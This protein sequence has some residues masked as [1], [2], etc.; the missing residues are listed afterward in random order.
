MQRKTVFF[1][2]FT[3]CVLLLLSNQKTRPSIQTTSK[4][5]VAN[6]SI[7]PF[8]FE[9]NGSLL[10]R[11]FWWP[12]HVLYHVF[13]LCFCVG[14]LSLNLNQYQVISRPH[15]LLPLRIASC[16]FSVLLITRP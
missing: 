3:Y 7:L 6:S 10:F 2:H 1:S 13:Q 15:S 12:V 11:L 4:S 8:L 16:S 5:R 14:G 9:T